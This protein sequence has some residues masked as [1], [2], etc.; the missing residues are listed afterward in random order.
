MLQYINI[1]RS[2]LMSYPELNFFLISNFQLPA[3]VILSL[4]TVT[5][6]VNVHGLQQVLKKG[7]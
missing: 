6:S 7:I 3:Y 5:L 1:L 2:I 4:A